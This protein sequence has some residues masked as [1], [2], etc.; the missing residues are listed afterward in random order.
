M[1]IFQDKE[2]AQTEVKLEASIYKEALDHRLSVPQMINRKYQ[3]S[4]NVSTFDQ[5][6]ASTGL[7]TGKNSEFGLR[8]PT[9]A[10]IFDGSAQLNAGQIVSD[11]NPA[12]RILFPAV[13][14][15]LLENKLLVDRMTDVNA[16][17]GM[18]AND[19]SITQDRAERP[20]IN[21]TGPEAG[22]SKPIGQLAKPASMLS[23]TTSD[24]NYA[25]PTF[26]LGMEVSDQALRAST[27]DL[28][29]LAIG[30]QVEVERNERV[31]GYLLAM[32]NGDVDMGDAA[33]SSITAASLDA[34]GVT[35]NAT[36]S[37][38]AWVK[39]LFRNITKRKIDYC[40]CDLDT[41]LAIENRSGKPTVNTDDP[42]SP[43]VDSLP[44][45]VNRNLQNVKFFIVED[46]KGWPANTIMGIDSRYAI[47][48]IR[49]SAASYTAVEDFV[50]TKSRALRF[51]FA[52]IVYRMFDE[53]FDVL[54]LTGF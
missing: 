6:C 53:A 18:I 52:E 32:L 10:S 48:R 34:T 7:F 3:T 38:L 17:E 46:G 27:L 25:I 19:S 12:S 30:R 8:T 44:T 13:I 33:L 50:L 9:L 49:N 1:P 39:F 45:I 54:T 24:S 16:F 37:H 42:T 23:F 14:L 4:A 51:D 11:A 22:R 47:Q 43:R 35:A 31:Y 20:I 15:E 28:V 29:T 2:G 41:Y 40:V 36:I 21:Y 26:A 5:F